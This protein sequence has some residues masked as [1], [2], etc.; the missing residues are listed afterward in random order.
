MPPI[1]A[2]KPKAMCAHG[3]PVKCNMGCYSKGGVAT[4][5]VS[6]NRRYQKGVHESITGG[7]AGTSTAGGY[8]GGHG[9]ANNPEKAKEMHREKLGELRSMKGPHGNYADGGDVEPLENPMEH[10]EPDGDE[11]G[12]M[13][14]MLADELLQAVEKKDRKGIASAIEAMV[15]E[16]MS[17]GHSDV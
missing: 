6:S 16:C 9:Y 11:G 2:K 1:H 5:T 3:G 10:K 15:M 8:I 13:G 12:E 17:K 7:D 14:E 4:E